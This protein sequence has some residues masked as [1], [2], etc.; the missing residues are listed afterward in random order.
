MKIIY[1]STHAHPAFEQTYQA[2]RVDFSQ[3]LVQSDVLSLHAPLTDKTNNLMSTKT[4][5]QM[6]PNAIFIN[7]ARGQMHD[8]EALLAAVQS[9][10]L[11][12]AGL[13][14]TN[15]EPISPNSKLLQEPRIVVLPHIGSATQRTR[16]KMTELVVKNILASAQDRP[17]LTEVK[18]K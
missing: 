6:K 8:E 17:L 16:N 4:F 9:R 7:T 11:F 14:V 18:L 12:A 2:K 3:L 5:A 10:H 1:C 15:P 13:D